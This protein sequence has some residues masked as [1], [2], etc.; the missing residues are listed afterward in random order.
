M[1]FCHMDLS[2]DL[3]ESRWRTEHQSCKLI[4]SKVRQ[5]RTRSLTLQ[6]SPMVWCG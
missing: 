6:D 1:H 5:E 4:E 3:K 2:L